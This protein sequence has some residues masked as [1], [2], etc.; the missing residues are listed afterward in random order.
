M[1]V[2]GSITYWIFKPEAWIILGILLVMLDLM[3]GFEFFILPV[4]MAAIIVAG[5]IYAQANLWFGDAIIFSTWKG[6][7]IWFAILSVASVGIIKV[8]FQKSKNDQPDINQ[9]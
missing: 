2:Y 9:Y 5:L 3:I 8:F 4:G 7:L 6:I 1:D